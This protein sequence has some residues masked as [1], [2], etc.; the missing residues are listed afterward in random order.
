[1]SHF[2]HATVLP[3]PNSDVIQQP[4]PEGTVLFLPAKEIYYGLNEVG[5]QIWSLL[6]PATSGF[7]ELCDAI[8]ARYPDVDRG[9]IET[10]VTEL[11]DDLMSQGLVVQVAGEADIRHEGNAPAA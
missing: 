7:S 4:L 11:L 5:S 9:V 3:H 8:S 1:M 10:D 6:P 2:N